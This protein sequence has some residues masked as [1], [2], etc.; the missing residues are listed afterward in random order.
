MEKIKEDLSKVLANT[1]EDNKCVILEVIKDGSYS[2]VEK[3]RKE[4]NVFIRKY[5]H[6]EQKTIG[7]L[8]RLDHT[9]LPKIYHSY[10]LADKIVI[11]EEYIEGLTL[12]DYVKQNKKLSLGEAIQLTLDLC[13]V[14]SFLHSQDPPIIHRDIKPKNIICTDNGVKLIDFNISR[15]YNPQKERDTEY[16]GTVGYAPP[17]QFGFGQTDMRSDI[18][19]IGKTLLFMIT[20][21]EPARHLDKMILGTLPEILQRV[22]YLSTNFTPQFRYS[23]VND[24]IKDLRSTKDSMICD[25]TLTQ[26]SGL[27]IGMQNVP[28][29]NLRHSSQ[30]DEHLSVTQQ[31]KS[32]NLLPLIA[33]LI[34]FIL[35]ALG[36]IGVLVASK[37][38]PL[39]VVVVNTDIKEED[40]PADAAGEE[41]D[42]NKEEGAKSGSPEDSP[43]SNNSVNSNTIPKQNISD[44]LVPPGTT[45]KFKTN[46]ILKIK[47][48]GHMKLQELVSFYQTAL[49][50]LGAKEKVSATSPT[51][52]EYIGFYDNGKEIVIEITPT[53]INVSY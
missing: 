53:T 22:V 35:L 13:E 49:V 21:L 43:S 14:V 15:S 37:D 33:G 23:S 41:H 4:G 44:M 31:S 9:A 45:V 36:V 3:I 25:D 29:H 42:G 18:F 34:A 48:T 20:G 12:Y 26:T 38:S 24:M 6:E 8:S 46:G 40:P 32:R 51:K 47:R 28:I 19:S 39:E 7:D 16:M 2:R 1:E 11:I 27:N 30:I 52:W 50:N 5:Y 17:E 10:R